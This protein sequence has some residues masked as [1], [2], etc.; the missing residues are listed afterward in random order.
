MLRSPKLRY[1]VWIVGLLW[2]CALQ[3]DTAL[4][5]GIQ[6]PELEHADAPPQLIVITDSAELRADA[7]T[8]ATLPQGE[9]VRPIRLEADRVQVSFEGLTGWLE[10]QHVLPPQAAID[11][12]TQAIQSDRQ[13]SG[14]HVARGAAWR[15][16]GDH[17]LALADFNDA[18]RLDPANAAAWRGRGLNWEAQK[19]WDKA[20]ADHAECLRLQDSSASAHFSRGWNYYQRKDYDRALSDMDAAI[21]LQ[22]LY[23]RPR[24]FRGYIRERRQDHAGAIEDFTEVLRLDPQSAAAFYA[25]GWNHFQQQTYT[26][27][28]TDFEDALRIDAQHSQ[29]AAYRRRTWAALGHYDKLAADYSEYLQSHPDDAAAHDRL[30]RLLATCPRAEIRNG[31]RAV[32][33]A[34]RACQL[35]QNRRP[36]FLDTLAAAYA[37]LNQFDDALTWQ[38][39]ALVTSATRDKDDF[40]A[41]MDLYVHRQ[42]LREDPLITQTWTAFV[43]AAGGYR[44]QFPG[45]PDDQV[46]HPEAPDHMHQSGVK[47]SN[48]LVFIVSYLDLPASSPQ[49]GL[50]TLRPLLLKMVS[51]LQLISERESPL[52]ESP[53]LELRMKS[54]INED[55]VIRSFLVGTRMYHLLVGG[56]AA[57]VARSPAAI[58]R[59]LDSFA[60]TAA[61]THSQPETSD[62]ITVVS[63]RGQFRMLFPL[64]PVEQRLAEPGAPVHYQLLATSQSLQLDFLM[65]YGELPTEL[66]QRFPSAAARVALFQKNLV[67]KDRLERE[68]AVPTVTGA[69]TELQISRANGEMSVMRVICI[70]N[71]IF[72]FGVAG[73]AAS[74]QQ[75]LG[76]VRSFLESFQPLP[77]AQ[78]DHAAAREQVVSTVWKEYVSERGRFRAEFPPGEVQTL[79]QPELDS[80]LHEFGIRWPDGGKHAVGYRDLPASEQRPS[81]ERRKQLLSVGDLM[82]SKAGG[83][84]VSAQDL[85]MLGFPGRE[86]VLESARGGTLVAIRIYLVQNR[87]YQVTV[88]APAERYHREAEA[89][90]HFLESFAILSVPSTDGQLSLTDIQP[91][92]GPQGPV[93]QNRL[94]F[95]FDTIRYRARIIGLTLDDQRQPD[96]ELVS[97]LLDPQGAVVV[98][99]TTRIKTPPATDQQGGTR[100]DIAIP[101]PAEPPAGEYTLRVTLNDHHAQRSAALLRKILIRPTELAIVSL[102]F[103]RDPD[104]TQPGPAGAAVG[105]PFFLR[106]RGV[107]FDR[108]TGRLET[109]LTLQLRN[110]QGHE[111]LNPPLHFEL[112]SAD[113]HKVAESPFVSFAAELQA[114]QAGQFTLELQLRDALTESTTSLQIPVSITAAP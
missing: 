108:S 98:S 27:A 110:A 11:Q 41:R 48:N 22:P 8:L 3:P 26:A 37:E 73:L 70:Q 81:A 45:Q 99:D 21:R 16:K 100:F 54:P 30:A 9:V 103:F 4:P 40:Q 13:N 86:V 89:I 111:L 67:G 82:A 102:E 59:F 14:L 77:A 91:C 92:Y 60:L 80:D 68:T 63:E 10:R 71:R 78:P 90:R 38:R 6:P 7:A 19:T 95:P 105:E 28:L 2:H 55:F 109:S 87:L 66:Q 104:G 97:E 72:M 107:G 24:L 88:F 29:A 61:S 79:Q 112:A 18:I 93:R 42:P 25:R 23:A 49:P 75:H 12:L 20:I 83:R 106:L 94:Y 44:I 57:D 15:A 69:G 74:V 1:T 113:P 39:R 43:S 76:A 65:D 53:G 50:Q 47:T 114:D 5:A 64:Q 35:S 32:E 62:W 17:A 31:Q 96:L 85:Q 36:A 52:G 51:N 33:L 46:D 84:I 101:V 58:S 56:A 34:Q